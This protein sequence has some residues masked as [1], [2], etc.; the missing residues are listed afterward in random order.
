MLRNYLKSI[1][2]NIKRNRSF[3]LINV[4]GLSL[5]LAAFIAIAEYVR[6]EQSFD[7]YHPNAEDIVRIGI[8][9][10]FGDGDLSIAYMGAPGTKVISADFPQ[11]DDATRLYLSFRR[12]YFAKIG[13]KEFK[14]A[15]GS[16]VM[17]E[18][19]FFS[20]FGIPLIQGNPDEVLDGPNKVVLTASTAE[21]YFGS[22]WAQ[23]NIIGQSLE[24]D[25]ELQLQITGVCEDVP[26]NTHFDFS[27]LVSMK[28]VPEE[29]DNFWLAN[30]FYHYF[31]LQEG[32]NKDQFVTELNKR[33]GDYLDGDIQK[34]LGKNYSDFFTD[35]SRYF[36][37]FYQ[38]ISDIHLTSHYELEI[39]ENGDQAYVDIF[40]GVA[41]LVLLMASI[42]FM[43]LSMVTG[44]KRYKEVGIRK[45]LG[46]LKSQVIFQFLLESI[47]IVLVS[48]VFA[49]TL[50]QLL[51]PVINGY[52]GAELLRPL[53]ELMPTIGM[54]ILGAVGL[55]IVSG[56]YPAWS[57]S[58][59]NPGISLKG[60]HQRGSR[61]GL[62][63]NGLIV[64]QFAISLLLII[65]VWGVRQQ[66][67]HM[68]NQ[69]L[70]YDK[71]QVLIIEDTHVLGDKV[72][73]FRETL[74]ANA[75]VKSA[76][77]SGFVPIGSMEYGTVGFELADGS[78]DFTQRINYA[79]IDEHYLDTYSIKLIEGRNFSSDFTDEQN[80]VIVNK[81][82]LKDW[83]WTPEE[84]LGKRLR[85]V[86]GDGIISIV[87][88]VEDFQ[89]LSMKSKGDPFCLA[90]GVDNQRIAVKFISKDWLQARE[91]TEAIWASFTDKPFDYTMADA[92]FE[93]TFQNEKKVS[94]L[95]TAFS[96]LA[97]FIGS[98]GL[99][100]VASY[101]I[102]QRSKEV[103][104]R[105]ILGA[106]IPQLYGELSKSFVSLIFIAGIIAIPTAYY[107]L[108]DWLGQYAYQ[109]ALS[110]WLFLV[111]FLFVGLIA[112]GII[113]A[114]IWKVA[115]INPIKS[116]RYE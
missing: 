47:I 88:V 34:F 98:L 43:N 41:V 107:F 54:L 38:N 50:I 36:N 113:G 102:V 61:A 23:Q 21:R 56:F 85:G 81:S 29:A 75:T 79:E 33:A 49:I 90:Y 25:D 65:S 24:V 26:D 91:A 111:P 97:L 45:V 77:I 116:L 27:L 104:I 46:S 72:S 28:T 7:D 71:E 14:E 94:Q 19:N 83:G 9:V 99:L 74:V 87:G 106:T 4:V 8:D 101:V 96:L 39:E 51:A 62:F 20:F 68:R 63:R 31:R 22:D 80:S 15:P 73:A 93:T 66:L 59:I 103:G 53:S 44:L 1:F 105:K 57:L 76:S 114:Q 17:A 48:L 42:N 6:F 109:V 115:I 78:R 40:L 5:G 12:D 10:N 67:S 69:D 60:V 82:F 11:V 84:A 92:L 3:T 37:F 52:F 2:R 86:G 95:F 64:F 13:E 32:T 55:G 18:E 35:D 30:S 89:V 100:G 110:W 16:R 58:S 70:G 108:G 112:L